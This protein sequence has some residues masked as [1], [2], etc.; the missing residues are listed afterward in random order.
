LGKNEKFSIGDEEE[1][2][3]LKKNHS[4]NRRNVCG[5]RRTCGDEEEIKVKQPTLLRE[6]EGVAESE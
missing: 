3:F 1:N 5:E 2:Q 6:G 4:K